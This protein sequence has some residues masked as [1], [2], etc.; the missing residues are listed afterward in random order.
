MRS[1]PFSCPHVPHKSYMK[2]TYY[3]IKPP[4]PEL[5]ETGHTNYYKTTRHTNYYKTTRHTD[6][7]LQDY[8]KPP[9]TAAWNPHGARSSWYNQVLSKRVVKKKQ[10]CGS[11]ILCSLNEK[12]HNCMQ[13]QLMLH[14]RM[15]KHT[16]K[17]LCC[18]DRVAFIKTMRIPCPKSKRELVSHW[19]P[20]LFS[21]RKSWASQ[22]HCCVPL[23]LESARSLAKCP[24]T[25][26]S[27]RPSNWKTQVYS[28]LSFSMPEIQSFSNSS[29]HLVFVSGRRAS[30]TLEMQLSN[31]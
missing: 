6:Q 12:L 24:L 5:H 28:V 13:H 22:S 26:S 17:V 11:F 8:M 14:Q 10:I 15:K 18:F 19:L 23:D 27:M 31:R 7:L 20:C 25:K 4:L 30:H 3:Y 2:H 21:A 29:I 16:C 9:W 1:L